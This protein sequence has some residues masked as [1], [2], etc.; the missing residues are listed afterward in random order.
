MHIFHKWERI[1][2]VEAYQWVAGVVGGLAIKVYVEA[3]QC[4]VCDKV[5][6]I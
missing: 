6:P 3:K 2:K 1:G 4:E 5:K